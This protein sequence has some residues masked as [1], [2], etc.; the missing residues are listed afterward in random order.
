MT[1]SRRGRAVGVAALALS[2]LQLAP[3]SHDELQGRA[4]S[5]EDCSGR[6]SVDKPVHADQ[7]ETPIV[8]V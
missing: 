1:A 2:R 7:R 8:A 4:A 3:R 6:H 5:G